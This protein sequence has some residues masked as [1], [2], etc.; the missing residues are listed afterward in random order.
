[1][2]TLF[3]PCESSIFFPNYSWAETKFSFFLFCS[4]ALFS[5]YFYGKNFDFC[6]NY[7]NSVLNPRLTDFILL[8]F[9]VFPS[10]N[11][12][13]FLL[14]HK[15]KLKKTGF[16]LVVSTHCTRVL[17]F[18]WDSSLFNI[19]PRFVVCMIHNIIHSMYNHI[20]HY[21]HSRAVY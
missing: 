21:C 3:V 8:S 18:K 20:F 2:D 4:P 5:L 10:P 9:S 19:P 12:T 7:Y 11:L 15:D 6:L 16:T 17:P 13:S 1:M 14:I